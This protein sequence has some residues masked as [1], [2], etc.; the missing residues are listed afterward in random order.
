MGFQIM[1]KTQNIIKIIK[2]TFGSKLMKKRFTAS[3]D[4]IGKINF[5]LLTSKL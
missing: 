4:A 5:Y 2:K 3:V 1:L